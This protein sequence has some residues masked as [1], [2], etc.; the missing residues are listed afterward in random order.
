MARRNQ[1]AAE[2][3]LKQISVDGHGNLWGLDHSGR[4]WFYE[5]EPGERARGRWRRLSMI[6]AQ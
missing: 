6:E 1:E 3:E 4:A 5:W 2:L